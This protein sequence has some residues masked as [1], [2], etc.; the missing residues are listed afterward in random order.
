MPATIE[1]RLQEA[2]A[3]PLILRLVPMAGHVTLSPEIGLVSAVRLIVPTKL[4]MLVRLTA[5]EKPIEP[6]LKSGPWAVRVKSPTW[7]MVPAGCVEDP[8]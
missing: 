4:F 5:T 8:V 7:T 6:A 1:A 3:V 2:E